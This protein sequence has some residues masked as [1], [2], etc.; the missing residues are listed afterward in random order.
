MADVERRGVPHDADM[1]KSEPLADFPAVNEDRV[2]EEAL[3]PT[4]TV[5]FLLSDVEGSTPMWEADRDAAASAIARHYELLDAAIVLHGGVRPLE[6]GEGDSVV[7]VFIRASDALAAALDMQRALSDEV[8]PGDRPLRVRMALHTGEA[9]LRSERVPRSGGSDLEGNYA[10]PAI[11]RCARLRSIAHGGQILV[12][13]AAHDLLIDN[14]VDGVT[15]RDLGLHRLKGLERLERVWQLRHPELADDL[16]APRSVDAT[17]SNLPEELTSFVARDAEV[18]EVRD[19]L[20]RQRV[21]TL[22][23]SGGCGKTRPRAA[24][25]GTRNGE[26]RGRGSLDR[27]RSTPRSR[28]GATRVGIRSRPPRRPRSAVDRDVARTVGRSR[29]PCGAGQL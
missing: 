10:G 26:L 15:W 2:G 1:A 23:G 8:W 6:Q 19:A 17:R 27:A 25:C 3:L 18:N 29:S 14:P 24:S 28:V 16:P 22:T 11:I 4:G 21:V 20:Q 9:Q 5:T 12:S 13:D 7:A